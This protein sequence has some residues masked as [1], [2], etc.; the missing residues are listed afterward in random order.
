[1]PELEIFGV[2]ERIKCV[3]RSISK[4]LKEFVGPSDC[5]GS[6]ENFYLRFDKNIF[7]GPDFCFLIL[8]EN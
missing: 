5:I 2:C 3:V 6:N 8:A 4:I 7:S 1:M